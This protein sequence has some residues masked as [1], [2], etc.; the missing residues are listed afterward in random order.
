[1]VSVHK[2]GNNLLTGSVFKSLNEMDAELAL[3][4]LHKKG[5]TFSIITYKKLL[6][7]NQFTKL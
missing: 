2:Y 3:D 4:T 5:S 7:I 1:M 6:L